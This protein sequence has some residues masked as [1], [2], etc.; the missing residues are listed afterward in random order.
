MSRPKGPWDEKLPTVWYCDPQKAKACNKAGCYVFGGPCHLT[1]DVQD[2]I[3]LDGEPMKG[4]IIHG[5]LAD[6]G[7]LT[8]DDRRPDDGWW[9]R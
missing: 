1:F 3:V 2:A 7:D 6:P 5:P 8:E 4:P 9:R